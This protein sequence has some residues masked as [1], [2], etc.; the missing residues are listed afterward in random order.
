MFPKVVFS[1]E[2]YMKYAYIYILTSRQV[3]NLSPGVR[4]WWLM[5]VIL[6]IEEAEIRFVVQGQPRKRGG[7]TRSQQT[8][9]LSHSTKCKIERSWSRPAGAKKPDPISKI[10]RAKKTGDMLK[11]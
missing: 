1:V 5:P 11:Q 9:H 10:T 3:K 4:C 8:H 6:A 2:M 7:K